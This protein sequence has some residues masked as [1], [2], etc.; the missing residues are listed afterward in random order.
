[1]VMFFYLSIDAAILW[2]L[3]AKNWLFG[4]DP[5]AGKDWRQEEKGTT[6]D[7][8]HGWHHQLNGNE[9]EQA[10]EVGDRQGSLECC[11]PWGYKESDWVTEL[12]W[13][14]YS[15][16]HLQLLSFNMY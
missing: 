13:S 12:S 14:I 6:E 16:R 9:F 8:M 4:K 2:P 11:S 15:K 7:K 10:L 1:M 5:S 3:D